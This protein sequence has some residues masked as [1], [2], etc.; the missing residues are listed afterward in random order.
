MSDSNEFE[1]IADG[2]YG[3]SLTEEEKEKHL[4]KVREYS[5]DNSI[6]ERLKN[7]VK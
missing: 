3:L 5:E 2:L 6:Y 7:W 4:E 1:K